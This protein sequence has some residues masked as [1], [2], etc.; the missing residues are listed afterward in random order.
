MHRSVLAFLRC[1][2]SKQELIVEAAEGDDQ[3]ETGLLRCPATGAQ[4]PIEE[5]IP[6]FGM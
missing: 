1:P 4:Y 5:G 6:R 3:I 2:V